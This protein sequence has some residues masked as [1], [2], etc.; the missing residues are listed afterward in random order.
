MADNVIEIE[1]FRN[2]TIVQNVTIVQ[3]KRRSDIKHL[4]EITKPATILIVAQQ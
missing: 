3:K 2:A 4:G 1:G